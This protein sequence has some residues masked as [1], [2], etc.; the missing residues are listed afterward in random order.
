MTRV[1]V[2]V[3]AASDTL[4][5]VTWRHGALSFPPYFIDRDTLRQHSSQ[6]R[7]DLRNLVSAATATATTAST[8]SLADVGPSLHA[9][10]R[11]GSAL[12]RTLFTREEGEGDPAQIDQWL[13][14]LPDLGALDFVVD[15]RVH[16][17][18]GLMY[19][20]APANSASVPPSVDIAHYTGFWCLRYRVAALFFRI[21]PVGLAKGVQGKDLRLIPIVNRGVYDGACQE[22]VAPLAKKSSADEESSAELS[23]IVQ[24]LTHD[25]PPVTQSAHLTQRWKQANGKPAII[26]FYCHANANT[27]ELSAEDL[28]TPDEL[29]H[30]LMPSSS[31]RPSTSLVILNGCSTAEGA[32]TGGFLEA[33]AFDGCCGFIGTEAPVPYLFALRFGT[34]LLRRML[35]SE[36]TVENIVAAMRPEHWPLS[37]LYSVNCYPSYMITPPA[38]L[39]PRHIGAG[40]YSQQPL[41]SRRLSRESWKRRRTCE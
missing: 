11:S 12:R 32:S 39:L 24:V 30:R 27:L 41:G 29:R 35:A 10:M 5:K 19:E 40:N 31:D 17:P 21:G 18:W 16:A 20:D 7:T 34:E 1:I 28:L 23:E 9:L 2:H 36:Q 33:V 26:Y 14:D 38:L 25:G 6:I 8:N 13:H 15:R 22:I 4:L 37:L 3:R